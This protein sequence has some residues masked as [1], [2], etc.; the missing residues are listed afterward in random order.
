MHA[1]A[2]EN[3]MIF[4]IEMAVLPFSLLPEHL[5]SY[6]IFYS[7]PAIKYTKQILN[8]SFPRTRKAGSRRLTPVPCSPFHCGRID[9]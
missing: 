5:S 6:F 4:Y 3:Y 8:M 9:T 2:N 7:N 1:F